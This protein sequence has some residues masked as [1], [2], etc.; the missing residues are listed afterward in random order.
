MNVDVKQCVQNG[1][2]NLDVAVEMQGNKT[3]GKKK[4]GPTLEDIETDLA[5][6][7]AI[8]KSTGKQ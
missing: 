1:L 6:L 8:G 4:K 3:K 7:L 5:P 2:E